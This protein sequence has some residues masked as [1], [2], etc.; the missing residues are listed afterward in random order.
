M[1]VHDFDIYDRILCMYV[2]IYVHGYV[3]AYIH[4]YIYTHTHTC[5]PE[6][7][8]LDATHLFADACAV[9]MVAL[10]ACIYTQNYA[11]THTIHTYIRCW[12]I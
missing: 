3:C 8:L 11:H 6:V 7:E 1:C 9:R 4:I 10:E 5:I 2:F 12:N